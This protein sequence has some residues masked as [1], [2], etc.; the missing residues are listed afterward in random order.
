MGHHPP[1]TVRYSAEVCFIQTGI[2]NPETG[3]LTDILQ[4]RNSLA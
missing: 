1:L 2:R 3:N 4:S